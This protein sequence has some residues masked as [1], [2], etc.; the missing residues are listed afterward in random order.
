MGDTMVHMQISAEAIYDSVERIRG[1]SLEL[2]RHR[3]KVRW[4][5]ARQKARGTFGLRDKPIKARTY[6]DGTQL[7]MLSG[8]CWKC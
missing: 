1:E 7:E 3:D 2:V 4:A 8:P 5:E 6:P